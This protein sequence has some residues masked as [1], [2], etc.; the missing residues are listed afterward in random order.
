MGKIA[1]SAPAAGRQRKAGQMKPYYQFPEHQTNH[2]CEHGVFTA[3]E[4]CHFCDPAPI[5]IHAPFQL[6][7]VRRIRGRLHARLL[8][9]W[10]TCYREVASLILGCYAPR[11]GYIQKEG[12]RRASRVDGAGLPGFLDGVH[13]TASTQGAETIA[14]K[15]K[16]DHSGMG[17]ND[18]QDCNWPFCGCDPYAN[19]VIEAIEDCGWRRP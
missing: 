15:C 9:A 10:G 13:T 7:T 11:Y 18:P 17:G 14:W 12:R 5:K 6:K 8:V 3:E 4:Y 16:A 19:K 1:G 2:A